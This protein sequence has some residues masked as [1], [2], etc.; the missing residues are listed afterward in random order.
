VLK[1]GIYRLDQLCRSR[2]GLLRGYLRRACYVGLYEDAGSVDGELG[3]KLEEQVLFG[4]SVA[5]GVF[6]RTSKDRMGDFDDATIAAV[7]RLSC[8]DRLL[9]VHDMAVSDARTAYDLFLKLSAALNDSIEFYATD[10]ALKVTAIRKCGSR[11]RVVVDGN[12]NIVQLVYPPF[13]LPMR[14]IESWLFPINRLLRVVLMRV[15]ANRVVKQ[16]QLGDP[17]LECRELQLICREARTLLAAR[18]NFHLDEYDLFEQAPRSYGLIRAMNIF[19][20]TYFPAAAIEVALV[21]V[22]ESLEEGGLFVVG[23]NGDAG[24]M[25]NGGI[26]AK[27]GGCF[28]AVYTSGSGAAIN[29]LVLQTRRSQ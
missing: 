26:Y 7:K 16:R 18:S 17:E 12:N 8:R 29:D 22:F 5:N 2:A 9:V 28:S 10:L 25:V 27:Q 11:T 13:V 23:S 14:A 1:L 6:K 4:F 20:L 3:R 19:N 15:V 21:N 24:S